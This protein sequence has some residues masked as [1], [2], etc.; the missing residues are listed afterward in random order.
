VQN[1]LMHARSAPTGELPLLAGD[2]LQPHGAH[3]DAGDQIAVVQGNPENMRRATDD[4]NE[5]RIQRADPSHLGSGEV[6]KPHAHP[7]DRSRFKQRTDSSQRAVSAV[8]PYVGEDMGS[9][10]SERREA[11]LRARSRHPVQRLL[12]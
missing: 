9:G 6:C 10:K 12:S 2:R 8:C 5:A 3:R 7:A 11:D 4:Q 1:V